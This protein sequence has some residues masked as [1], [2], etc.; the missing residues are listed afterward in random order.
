LRC[1]SLFR[2]NLKDQEIL[3]RPGFTTSAG[4]M[5][6]MIPEKGFFSWQGFRQLAA[7][8]TGKPA[9]PD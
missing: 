1:S 4:L 3:D 9:C 5:L 8:M 6:L 7:H 2:G